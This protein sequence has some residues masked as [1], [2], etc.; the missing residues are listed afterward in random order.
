[1]IT[2]KS[3]V[4]F[5]QLGK[6]NN[7]E[8]YYAYIDGSTYIVCDG[9][10]GSEKG[11][12]ASK[13]VVETLLD[14]Y[15]SNKFIPA[16]R[17]V[18]EAEQAFNNY[19]KD[20]PD[21]Q[22]M[23]TTLALLQVRTTHIYIAWVGDSRIYQFRKGEIVF[24]TRD[25]SWVNEA[26][27]AGIL[28]LKEAIDHPKRNI[29]TRAIQGTQKPVQVQEHFITNVSAGDC[30]LLCS[31]GVLEAWNDDDLVALFGEERDIDYIQTRLMEECRLYSKDNNTAIVFQ[32]ESESINE[33][34]STVN[35]DLENPVIQSPYNTPKH[36]SYSFLLKGIRSKKISLVNLF[37]L[38]AFIFCAF[39]SWNYFSK[40]RSNPSV[41]IKAPKELINSVHKVYSPKDTAVKDAINKNLPSTE[42]LHEANTPTKSK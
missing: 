23:A 28:S 22:G 2:V 29:I 7:N 5:S 39:L 20:Y 30:F 24:M 4:V 9:V 17:A 27:D 35:L 26:V 32:V 18:I 14:L 6:R 41:P 16:Q 11:E 38:A 15:K 40:K 37:M 1:M 25:H 31:D 42:L 21:S 33:R 36:R 8:D 34:N 13:I 19:F 10:G 12:I 3:P